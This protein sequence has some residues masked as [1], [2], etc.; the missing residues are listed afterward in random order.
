VVQTRITGLGVR[1]RSKTTKTELTAGGLAALT[2][3]NIAGAAVVSGAES[4]PATEAGIASAAASADRS[5]AIAS[6][7]S[8]SSINNNKSSSYSSSYVGAAISKN[9]TAT[10]QYVQ[11]LPICQ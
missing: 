1:L 11:P 9:V 7:F 3:G 5:A 8:T 4:L 2:A 6:S 10:L